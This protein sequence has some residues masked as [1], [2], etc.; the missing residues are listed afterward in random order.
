MASIRIDSFKG[1]APAVSPVKLA[2]GAAQTSLNARVEASSLVPEK[3]PTVIEPLPSGTLSMYKWLDEYWL[4]SDEEE[5]FVES[6]VVNDIW[7][8]IY[9]AGGDYPRYSAFS[10]A[11][12][13]YDNTLD[14]NASGQPRLPAT[15]YRLGVPAHNTALTVVVN[16]VADADAVEYTTAYVCTFV[17]QFGEEGPPSPATSFITHAENQTRTITLPGAP[18][19]N[20]AFGSG[21]L[22]RI[23]RTATGSSGSDFLF[24]AEVPLATATYTDS[25]LPDDLG[26]IM[27]SSQWFRPLDDVSSYAPD[28]PLKKLALMSGGFLA[29]FAGRVVAF[30]EQFLPHAW[31]PSYS[32]LTESN[33]VAIQESSFGLAILTE[34]QPYVAVGNTPSAMGLAKLDIDQACVS[35]NSVADLGGQVIYAS[36]D[37]LVSIAG[38]QAALITDGVITREQWQAYVPSSIRGVAFE[39]RYYAFYD[40]GSVQRC[41]V[42]DPTNPAAPFMEIDL[43]ADIHHKSAKDD[44][45]YLGISDNINEFGTGSNKTMS[46]KSKRYYMSTDI[47][48]AW[49]R[50]ISDGEV[51]LRITVDD[52]IITTS[53]IRDSYPFRLPAETR[54][55]IIEV[56]IVSATARVDSIVLA[57]ERVEI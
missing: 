57:S 44:V 21:S 33:V 26:E 6:P 53:T 14:L 43:H 42:Y 34:T 3:S 50:V 25:T 11:L 2:E 17:T 49:A 36:P 10:V 46:W 29:G 12:T 38:N 5:S 16:G 28:G 37:G 23:Y 13:G 4:T 24:V 9:I 7:R 39:N 32:L 48:L 54:G 55:R 31:D 8:R 30:S 1:F 15:S 22:I 27:P 40:T 45:L 41:I 56:E 19:G 51:K 52:T 18:A 47:N 35:A 20:Y